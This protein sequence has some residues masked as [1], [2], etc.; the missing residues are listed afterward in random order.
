MQ[1]DYMMWLTQN[2]LYIVLAIGALL[3][4]ALVRS[5][6]IRSQYHDMDDSD[7]LQTPSYE[8]MDSGI[9]LSDDDDP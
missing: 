2:I 5:F 7:K 1:F 9:K 8:R 4:A 3:V 6:F